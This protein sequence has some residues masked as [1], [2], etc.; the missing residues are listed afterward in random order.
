MEAPPR[1]TSIT[2]AHSVDDTAPAKPTGKSSNCRKRGA[3]EVTEATAS[4]EATAS[5]AGKKTRRETVTTFAPSTDDLAPQQTAKAPAKTT[6]TDPVIK[7]LRDAG[8]STLGAHI[9]SDAI[10]HAFL[11]TTIEEAERWNGAGEEWEKLR[12]LARSKNFASIVKTCFFSA[13]SDTPDT[14]RPVWVVCRGC[15]AERGNSFGECDTVFLKKEHGFCSY[16][17][18]D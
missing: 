9:A 7:G 4:E 5:H 11:P 8:M 16:C 13:T 6:Q 10:A 1:S 15:L 17:G 14:E 2:P 3:Q 18:E 12:G